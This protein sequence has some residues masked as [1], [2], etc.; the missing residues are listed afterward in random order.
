MFE[1]VV[2]VV[3]VVLVLGYST[4][5]RHRLLLEPNGP[6]SCSMDGD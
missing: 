4:F 2:V 3:V 1:F 5:L 6:Q